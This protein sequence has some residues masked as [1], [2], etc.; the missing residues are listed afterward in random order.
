MTRKI[1]FLLSLIFIICS[2][3]L[4]IYTGTHNIEPEYLM[5]PENYYGKGAKTTIK[6]EFIYWIY[7][8]IVFGIGNLFFWGALSIKK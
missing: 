3:L 4:M 2:V 8:M 7:S 6:S 1:F 5:L